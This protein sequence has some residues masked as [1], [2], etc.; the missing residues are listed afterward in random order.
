MSMEL[1]RAERNLIL[2]ETVDRL[3]PIRWNAMTDAKKAEWENFRKQLL[4]ITHRIPRLDYV[5]WPQVPSDKD[6]P[7]V[8]EEVTPEIP[9]E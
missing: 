9:A 1:I 3:N 4:D 7:V 2:N 8:T 5:S 6:E